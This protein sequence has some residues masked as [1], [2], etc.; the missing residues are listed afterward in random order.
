[1]MRRGRLILGNGQEVTNIGLGFI[2]VSFC[3]GR[4]LKKEIARQN[5][6]DEGLKGIAFGFF[7]S[8]KI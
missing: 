8:V 2:P 4:L 5:Q 3:V 1:M 6:L 7:R